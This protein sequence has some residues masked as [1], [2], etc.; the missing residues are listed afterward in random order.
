MV[1]EKLII[2]KEQIFVNFENLFSREY[3]HENT[4]I[5]LLKYLLKVI[6]NQ[7]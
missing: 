7:L 6:Q 2:G 5:Y 4:T 1:R 3:H